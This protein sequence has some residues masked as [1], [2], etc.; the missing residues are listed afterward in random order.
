MTLHRDAGVTSLD[1]LGPADLVETFG[2][3]DR[4]PVLNVYLLALTLRDAL[5]Q[6]RD[7][8][9]ALRREG[10]IVG[11]LHL[12]GQ[13]GAVLPLGEGADGLAILAEHVRARLSFLPTRFQVIGPRAAV[14]AVVERLRRSET[15]PRLLRDQL[16]MALERGRLNPFDRL[17][18]LRRACPDDFDL[19]YESGALLRAEEL[20]EDPRLSDPFGYAKRVEEECRDGC[21]HLW[22]DDQGLCFRASV[23]A[24]TPDAAQVSGVFTPPERRN[25]RL[26]RR[27]LSELCLRLLERS[28][29]V[30]LFV[31]EFNTPAVA[32]YRRLGFT[33]LADWGS[34]FYDTGPRP[35]GSRRSG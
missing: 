9:W 13:S 7:E 2:Y 5:G 27:G 1:R 25:L 16:Y 29:S 32:L 17:P 18:E 21:T 4:D 34:A 19:A 35:P 11:L 30:C 22:R 6:P 23:S 10:E 3:L 14:R 28:R 8:F 33:T 15:H 31:N 24:L 26:A 12:G 20:E